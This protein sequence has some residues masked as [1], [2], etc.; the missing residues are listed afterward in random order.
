[1]VATVLFLSLSLFLFLIL[2][3]IVT[4]AQS[5]HLGVP[6]IAQIPSVEEQSQRGFLILTTNVINDNGGSK[7]ASD[8]II[9][10]LG[11]PAFPSSFQA[12]QTPKV[13]IISIQEGYYSVS[14]NNT[15]GYNASFGN[16]CEGQ[17]SAGEIKSCF[18]T[19]DES[20]TTID[21]ETNTPQLP[22]LPLSFPSLLLPPSQ[23]SGEEGEKLT[24]SQIPLTEEEQS[25]LGFLV[26]GTNV[27]NDNGGS[28]QASDFIINVLVAL[29]FLPLSKQL[30]PI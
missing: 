20:S 27:I 6:T 23:T 15:Q 18:I 19:L 10:V 26:V 8:F 13:Q 5:D 29:P 12:A 2:L 7:Q 21:K 9:N 24:I 16:Q 14:V 4:F 17:I 3:P 25:E 22:M 1:M 30:P 11:S 28:K